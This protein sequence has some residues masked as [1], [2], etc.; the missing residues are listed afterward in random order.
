VLQPFARRLL[1]ELG[2]VVP[3]LRGHGESDAPSDGYLPADYAADLAELITMELAPPLPVVGH[4]L[5]ALVGMQLA[6]TRPELVQWLVLLDPPLDP[7]LR[8]TE[9]EAVSLLRHASGGEL[10]AY[11]LGRNPGG[12]ELLA[13]T[14]AREFRKAADAAFETYLSAAPLAA[15]PVAART[16]LI[17]AD[18]SRGG[19]L[20]DQAAAEAVSRLGNATRL[21]IDGASHTVHASHPAEVA[22]AIRDFASASSVHESRSR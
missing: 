9:V 10:E 5:G 22:A 8:T 4:S 13:N 16:L 7:E 12:G 1:P 2:A 14:L 6:A 11:L 21:K 19:V 20:G 17:Q 18:P 3:D 15:L